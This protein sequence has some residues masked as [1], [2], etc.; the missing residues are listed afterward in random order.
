MTQAAKAATP[1]SVA[2]E[3]IVIA[4]ASNS[5]VKGCYALGFAGRKTGVQALGLL[6]I[7]AALG[8]LPLLF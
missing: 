5:V 4:A 8:L 6:L 3:A 1:L 2:A 7:F